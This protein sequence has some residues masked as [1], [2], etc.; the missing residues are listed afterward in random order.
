M[1]YI[2]LSL[3]S[4]P[5]ALLSL[6][7]EP[8][9][10]WIVSLGVTLTAFVL[11]LPLLWSRLGNWKANWR[12]GLF[13]GYVLLV[14]AVRGVALYYLSRWLEVGDEVSLSVRAF[15]SAVY[16]AI[17]VLTISAL[18]AVASE[19]ADR[20]ERHFA[21]R[22]IEAAKEINASQK[23]LAAKIDTLSGVKLLGENLKRIVHALD[24]SDFGEKELLVAA[25]QI[26]SEVES[27]LRPLSHKMWFS[28][29]LSRPRFRV[30][31]L[32]E[33]SLFQPKFAPLLTGV[34]FWCWF[35][36]GGVT[37]VPLDSLMAGAMASGL[38]VAIL[39]QLASRL[40]DSKVIHPALGAL[41]L[42]I[43]SG[44]SYLGVV[45]TLSS[46]STREFQV[47]SWVTG[48]VFPLGGLAVL[49]ITS[50]FLTMRENFL[51]LE[52]LVD[53]AASFA[54]KAL[55]NEFAGYLHNTLQSELISFALK[56]ER[57]AVSGRSDEP[58]LRHKLADLSQRSIGSH[59]VTRSHSPAERLPKV[60]EAWKGIIDVRL[61]V[62][63]LER[64]PFGKNALLLELVEESITNAV[65]H[66]GAPWIE[67]KCFDTGS[68][69]CVELRNPISQK[70]ESRNSLGAS[71]LQANT[72]SQVVRE[73][74]EGVRLT[75]ITL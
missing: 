49:L 14:G 19:G 64:V 71:W 17:W 34:I 16:T 1:A 60:I 75:T 20:Y 67:I 11:L 38:G 63:E 13:I 12:A 66:A 8:L 52:G 58:V 15:N 23:E 57:A 30:I 4:V 28:Q 47:N 59:F 9:R 41:L 65:R 70:K 54:S 72:K 74:P 25:A 21:E 24:R 45:L 36:I 22:A 42:T 18:I 53:S 10:L 55:S 7:I 51:L 29:A 62:S 44:L 50:I 68:E 37:T 61:E 32:I 35:V 26:K 6:E 5:A 27:S 3:V 56:L 73:T 46:I 43:V 2:P 39:A 69:F 33:E 31:G 48:L 40:L